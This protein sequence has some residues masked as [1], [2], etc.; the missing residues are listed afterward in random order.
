LV[1]NATAG[2][3]TALGIIQLWFNYFAASFSRHLATN[4]NVNY[5]KFPK[6]HRGPHKR[7]SRATCGP[8]AACLRPLLQSLKNCQQKQKYFF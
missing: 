8:R 7:A 3:K 4:L 2:R 6:K 1:C 5:L